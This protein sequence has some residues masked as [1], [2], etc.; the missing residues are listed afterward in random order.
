MR[1]RAVG[2]G[3]DLGLRTLS[4]A[5]RLHPASRPY[6]EAIE[7]TRDIPYRDGTNPAH[8][9]DVVR[10]RASAPGLRPVVLYLHGGGF[11][12]LSKETHWMMA[13]AFASHGYVVFNANYRLSG[14]ACFPAAI[15]DAARALGW[16]LDHAA[17]WGGDPARVVLAGES[18]GANLVTALTV[19]CCWRRSETCVDGLFERS[20]VPRAVVPMCGILEVSRR[21]RFAEIPMPT[22]ARDRI[23][24]VCVGYLGTAAEDRGSHLDLANPLTVLEGDSQP[25]RPLPPFA[26]SVG[27]RDPILDD[28]RRLERA[29]AARSVRHH[30]SYHFGEPHA[31]QALVWRSEARRAWRELFAFLDPVVAADAGALR[32][33]SADA[34][35]RPEGH[36]G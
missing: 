36:E 33:R 31:F 17:R 29:L 2:R 22:F 1:Q 35:V 10:P 19:G 4:R 24:Q 9:L 27:T 14:E 28:T 3:L 25:A 8:R 15:E 11:R 21:H 23:E 7:T 20:F 13:G 32:G 6:L 18:A 16:V 26:A 30:V 12:I 5:G 34:V